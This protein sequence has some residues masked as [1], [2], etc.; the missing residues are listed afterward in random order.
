MNE[1]KIVFYHFCML[2]KNP[3]LNKYT[4]YDN[5]DDDWSNTKS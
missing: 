4:I 1:S 5:D 2:I 3:S